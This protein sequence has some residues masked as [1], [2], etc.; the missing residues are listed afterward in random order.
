M[1]LLK[2]QP[3][4]VA[5]GSEAVDLGQTP[6]DIVVLSAADTE[7]AS[8]AAARARLGEA[9]PAVRLANLMQLSHN[10]SVDLYCEEI[11]ARARLVI[12][13]LLGGKSLLALRGRA[14]RRDLHR[15]RRDARAAARRRSARPGARRAFH[16]RVRR[17]PAT[18]ELPP[19]RRRSQRKKLSRLCRIADRPPIRVAGAG[20][21]AAGR[22]LLARPGQPRS[23][24]SAARLG[25]GQARRGAR[26]LPRPGAG[27]QRRARP[28]PDRGARPQ[29]SQ[30]PAGVLHEPEGPRLGRGHRVAAH[31]ERGGCGA[32]RDRVRRLHARQTDARRAPERYRSTGAAGGV[33]RRQREGVA[34][35]HPGTLGPGHRHERGAARGRR[36]DPFPRVPGDFP[37]RCRLAS[38]RVDMSGSSS[39]HCGTMR[40]NSSKRPVSTG[41]TFPPTRMVSTTS[42]YSREGRPISKPCSTTILPRT[43]SACRCAANAVFALPVAGSSRNPR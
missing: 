15:N 22:D 11:I 38:E 43:P 18:L 35:R 36:S 28:G 7:L 9:F 5:D 27:R 8:L 12:V 25:A 6:G 29:Q 13:R 40:F 37:H 30:L 31:R 10:A 41:R 33:L 39:H 42:R 14:D 32:E 34:L 24:R 20:R 21:A 16:R 4:V 3:G 1:H 19:A 26:L 17:L 23:E 2:A